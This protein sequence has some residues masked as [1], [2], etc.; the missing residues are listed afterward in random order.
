MSPKTLKNPRINLMPPCPSPHISNPQFVQWCRLFIY[1]FLFSGHGFQRILFG[2]R[3]RQLDVTGRLHQQPGDIWRAS[4]RPHEVP[5][6]DPR[7]ARP[8][9]QPDAVRLRRGGRRCSP[10]EPGR[11]EQRRGV[12][13]LP[14]VRLD[15]RQRAGPADPNLCHRPESQ[16]HL[17]V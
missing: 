9:H 6:G 10:T 16:R 5:M 11:T 3:L 8:A 14:P 12:T 2:V 1:L 17:F 7:S 15:G 13:H 4:L